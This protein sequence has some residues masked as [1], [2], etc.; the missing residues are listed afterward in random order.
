[1][2]MMDAPS[3]D[4]KRKRLESST[5]AT[6]TVRH[7]IRGGKGISKKRRNTMVDAKKGKP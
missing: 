1:M 4:R 5:A 3:S 7:S 6:R 2:K